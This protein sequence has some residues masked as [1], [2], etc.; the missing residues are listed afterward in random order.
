MA[1]TEFVDTDGGTLS[2]KLPKWQNTIEMVEEK[3]QIAG[4]C[5]ARKRGGEAHVF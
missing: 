2:A 5:R 4:A 1:I 3:A